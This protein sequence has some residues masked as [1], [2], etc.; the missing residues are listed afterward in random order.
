VGDRVKIRAFLRNGEAIAAKLERD[1]PRVD[2]R[3][4]LQGPVD[5]DAS[6]T[7]LLADPLLQIL[8]VRVDSSGAQFENEEEIPIGRT[9]F[10]TL[11]GRGVLVKA[12]GTL[13]ADGALLAR[14][15]ELEDER[16]DEFEFEIEME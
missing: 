10:F 4:R 8:G 9:A 2:G 3:V 7:P 6:G 13:S 5:V 1:D 15:V 12:T 14:Q 16:Q 11:L